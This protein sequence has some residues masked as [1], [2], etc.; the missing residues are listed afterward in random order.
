M[1]Y[2]N[3]RVTSAQDCFSYGTGERP[4]TEWKSIVLY[5]EKSPVWNDT[6]KLTLAPELV[7][8]VHLYF[9]IRHCAA[10][11]GEV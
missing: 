1:A 11:E 4:V 10:T 3:W 2:F 6:F 7:H 5:H 9:N 8:R